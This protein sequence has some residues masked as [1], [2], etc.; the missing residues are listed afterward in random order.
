MSDGLLAGKRILVTGVLTDASIAFAVARIAQEQGA[1]VVL[2]SFGRA[3]SITERIAGRLP[4][5]PAIVEL[6]VTNTGDLEALPQRLSA[7]I[8]GQLGN[9]GS[10]VAL[11]LLV[12][13]FELGGRLRGALRSAASGPA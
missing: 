10:W 1:T 5:R 8:T 3:M 4:A 11:G 6:D 12:T 7:H 9:A 13:G 2:S